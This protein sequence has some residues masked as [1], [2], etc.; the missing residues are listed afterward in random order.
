MKT[1]ALAVLKAS[2]EFTQFEFER[3]ELRQTISLSTFHM[4]EYVI[5]IFIK[6]AK[7]GVQRYFLW[8]PVTRLLELL[9]PSVHQ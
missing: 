3:R 7:N 1:R 4:Q 8:F 6:H 2:A 9:P 5:Q